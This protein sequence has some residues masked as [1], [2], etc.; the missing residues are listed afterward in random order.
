MN[1]LGFLPNELDKL[2][3][4]ISSQP[5]V[6]VQSIYSHLAEADNPN[7]KYTQHQIKTFDENSQKITKSLPYPVLRHIL[8]SEGILNYPDGQFS[9]VRIGIG[10]YGITNNPTWKPQLQPAISW[11][12]IVSQIRTIPQGASVGYG[13]SFIA[14][15][16]TK[17]AVIPVGYADG[18]ARRLSEGK[19]GVYIRNRFCPTVGK[20]CMDMIMVNVGDLDI[21]SGEKVEIIGPNQSMEELAKKMDTIP[22]EVMTRFSTRIHRVFTEK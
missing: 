8:N 1:R 5:E 19:G 21:E 11:W 15:K 10:M 17:I 13:R 4:L 3:Q 22:Y 6:R 9:M 20:V 14:D 2:I 18:Y 7:S 12:S 16:P